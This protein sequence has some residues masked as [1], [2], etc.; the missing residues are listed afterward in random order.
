MN[1]V[2]RRKKE[3][4]CTR[5]ISRKVEWKL[6]IGKLNKKSLL[7]NQKLLI[8]NPIIPA[9][10]LIVFIFYLVWNSTSMK[11]FK[12]VKIKVEV[13]MF[14]KV[15]NNLKNL[16]LKNEILLRREQPIRP[17]KNKTNRVLLSA[18]QI[19]K[20]QNDAT[21]ISKKMCRKLSLGSS[22]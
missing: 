20:V 12:S 17:P 8:K 9:D 6:N 4:K 7:F 15:F 18:L 14:Q 2:H 5:K 13:K 1:Y 21:Q 3:I 22:L 19:W 10:W 16:L 11:V